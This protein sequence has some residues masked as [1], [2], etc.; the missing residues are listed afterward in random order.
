MI[1]MADKE[2]GEKHRTNVVWFDIACLFEV[3]AQ[4]GH[5][6]T[7]RN[8]TFWYFTLR[9]HTVQTKILL[10]NSTYFIYCY[11]LGLWYGKLTVL[12]FC[13]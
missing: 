5:L 7:S 10:G 13:R 12:S 3:L 2:A 8:V 11:T 9:V 6:S 1:I 4:S